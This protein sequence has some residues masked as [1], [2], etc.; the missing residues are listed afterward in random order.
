[1]SKF[2]L[3]KFKG[4]MNKEKSKSTFKRY[5]QDSE[6]KMNFEKGYEELIVS[7]MLLDSDNI[8]LNDF[9]H[10]AR[11]YGYKLFLEKGDRKILI[12]G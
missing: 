11:S 7:E 2:W 3:R 10:T 9:I 8:T 5:M 1:M 4:F 12:A 6:F